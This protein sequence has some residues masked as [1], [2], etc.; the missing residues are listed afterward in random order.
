MSDTDGLDVGHLGEPAGIEL[1]T[2]VEQ[3]VGQGLR[4][5]KLISYAATACVIRAIDD[6]DLPFDDLDAPDP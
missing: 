5:A 4:P 2:G 1:S 3:C 6:I